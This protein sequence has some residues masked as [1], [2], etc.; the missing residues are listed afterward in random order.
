MNKAEQYEQKISII[1]PVYKVEAYLRQCIDSIL[2]QTYQNF[3]LILV[4]DGSPDNCGAI[5]DEYA[6]QDNRIMVIHQD[7]SGVSAARNAVIDW[8]MEHSNSCWI[9]FVDSDDCI[10]PG[11]LQLLAETAVST[12]AD[13]V[14][15]YGHRFNTEEERKSASDTVISTCNM[16]G[17]ESCASYYRDEDLVHSCP[18][19]KLL[20]KNLLAAWRFPLGITF[21]EDEALVIRLLY[22]AQK[23]VVLRAWPYCYRMHEDSAIHRPFALWRYDKL[24]VIDLCIDFFREQADPDL[25]KLARKQKIRTKAEYKVRAQKAGMDGQIPREYDLPILAAY[26][27][28]LY[29][30]FLHGG[31]K[32]VK[33]RIENFVRMNR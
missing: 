30:T 29:E 20:R 4:D 24:K 15:T 7:N 6:A 21:A 10:V 23:V 13:V 5:C 12:G 16:S 31:K 9:T 22:V 17:R 2:A 19:G 14:L 18:W 1:V 28:V 32:L 27:I 25:V 3:E 33:K 11:Y 26:L 8:V